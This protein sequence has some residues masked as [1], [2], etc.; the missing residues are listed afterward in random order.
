MTTAPAQGYR[1][2]R[3]EI[4]NFGGYHGKTCVFDFHKKGAIFS[5]ENGAGKSTAIDAYR[6]LFRT[7]PTFNSATLQQGRNDRTVET[8]YLGQYG[9]KDGPNGQQT[10]V[11]RSAGDKAMFMGVCGV[12]GNEDGTLFSAVRLGYLSDSTNKMD[13]RLITAPM[14]LSIERDFPVFGTRAEMARAAGE[15]GAELHP[16][17]QSFFMATGYTFGLDTW[18]EVEDAF[19][20]IDESIGVKKL[21][22]IAE[23]ARKHV[24]PQV[25]LQDGTDSVIQ[26][27]KDIK[28]TAAAVQRIET[29][30]HSMTKVVDSLDVYEKL[31]GTLQQAWNRQRRFPQFEATCTLVQI[32]LLLRKRRADLTKA[33]Q[34]LAHH[35]NTA[36]AMRAQIDAIDAAL[37]G[38]GAQRIEDLR[39]R[40]AH[41]IER[42]E[43]ATQTARNLA[44]EFARV[45]LTLD[46]SS[47]TAYNQS[48][49]RLGPTQTRAEYTLA[50]HQKHDAGLRT[51]LAAATSTHAEAADTVRS[52]EEHKTA[53]RPDIVKARNTLAEHLGVEP[54]D[55]PF[56]GELVRVRPEDQA[57][58]GAANRAL[59]ATATEILVRPDLEHQAI[60]CVNARHW[61]TKLVLNLARKH[62]H[63]TADIHPSSLF[64]KLEVLRTSPLAETA[65]AIL[66]ARARHVCVSA[67]E[68]NDKSLSWA[69][70]KEGGVKQNN[71]FVKDDRS[72]VQDRR[73]WVLGWNLE[74]RLMEAKAHAAHAKEALAKAEEHVRQSREG[75]RVYMERLEAIRAIQR[76]PL[77][78]A[79]IDTASIQEALRAIEADIDTI[80]TPEIQSLIARKDTLM[81]DIVHAQTKGEK[82]ADTLS[83]TKERMDEYAKQIRA[84]RATIGTETARHG[85][86]DRQD[87]DEYISTTIKIINHPNIIACLQAN[88]ISFLLTDVRSA[89]MTGERADMKVRQHAGIVRNNAQTYLSAFTEENTVLESTVAPEKDNAQ[90]GD[91]ERHARVRQTWKDRHAVLAEND[92][93]KHRKQLEENRARFAK[94]SIQGL[95]DR[96]TAYAQRIRAM[97]KGINA[98]LEHVTYDPSTGS[99]AVLRVREQTD[100][101]DIL[102]FA[103]KLAN[104]MRVS[105][106]TDEEIEAAAEGVIDDISDDTTAVGKKRRDA[107]LSLPNWFDMDVEEYIV[108]PDGLRQQ[109]RVYAGR[110]GTSGGQGERLTMLLLGSAFS[111]TFGAHD[112]TRRNTGLQTI[113]LDEAFMHGSEGTAQAATELLDAIGLQMIAA[114]PA[115][116]LLAFAG[117][118]ERIF[119]IL[120]SGERIQCVPSTY[121]Q[122]FAAIGAP[123]PA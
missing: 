6:L 48:Y 59:G 86:M 93:P 11:L 55:L 36:N 53:M 31:L 74:E 40:R 123:L 10:Q 28:E 102:R 38:N 50:Q 56:I 112:D 5:G 21:G 63:S 33:T 113:V 51:V 12:F 42:L 95:D 81:A 57:W 89:F 9:K 106:G 108:S 82:A 84:A 87:R 118:T 116:K 17:F 43:V 67:A 103:K 7:T 3:L 119:E 117:K 100:N 109:V 62:G 14:D 29:K 16:N 18:N 96:I 98:I 71:S 105:Y 66:A 46:T 76:K 2:L 77:A 35:K 80:N 32:Y 23:F 27:F 4:R 69:I 37:Q 72:P 107:I 22:S 45:G 90:E 104:A 47:Q 97:E 70:T 83:R 61:G 73:N 122:L 13:W 68:L 20:F 88:S 101:A 49:E 41:A 39:A 114:T 79:T 8:Y 64:H 78:F 58:E 52:I 115:E 110:D 85:R 120:K 34:D 25:S 19:R 121:A 65:T 92:L 111:H 94:K 30:V 15:L 44:E 26:S 75:E 1:L 54:H 91:T 99:R 60:A 24:F